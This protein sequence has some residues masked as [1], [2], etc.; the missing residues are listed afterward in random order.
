[1]SPERPVTVKQPVSVEPVSARLPVLPEQSEEL[2]NPRWQPVPECFH[3][4]HCLEGTPVPSLLRVELV[5]DSPGS[6]SPAALRPPLP[7][8]PIFP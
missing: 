2:E 7:I 5:P 8:Q 3:F 6:S 4:V 1:M